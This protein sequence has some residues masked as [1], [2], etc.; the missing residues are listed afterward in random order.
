MGKHPFYVHAD[1]STYL[2]ETLEGEIDRLIDLLNAID[3]DPDL[4]PDHDREYDPDFEPALGWSETMGAGRPM[5][6]SSFFDECFDDGV[7]G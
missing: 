3:A 1:Y 2:R 5:A 4:E 6:V 7:M